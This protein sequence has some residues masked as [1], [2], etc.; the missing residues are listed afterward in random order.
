[1]V[2]IGSDHDAATAM[3]FGDPRG[4][5]VDRLLEGD[6]TNIEIEQADAAGRLGRSGFHGCVARKLRDEIRQ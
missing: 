1:M 2:D 4:K 6:W 3:P 5:Q